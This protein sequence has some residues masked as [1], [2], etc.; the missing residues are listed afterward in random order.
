MSKIG[1]HNFFLKNKINIT[2]GYT[3]LNLG[4]CNEIRSLL[5]KDM[6]KIMEI[7]FNAGHSAELFLKNNPD[8]N[9]TSFDLGDHGYLLYGKEYID[10]MF[11]GRHTLIIGDSR[12]S[13]PKFIR[14]YPGVK[15]DLLFIDGGHEYEIAKAD[16]NNCKELAHKD[17]L[18]II[19][20]W[21]YDGLLEEIKYKECTPEI[22]SMIYN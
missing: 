22:Q 15:F 17:S 8:L 10:K 19:F 11:P 9:L 20:D 5:N 1:L 18:F 6:N 4:Q 16:L 7:G 13:I 21:S 3:Q 2:E 12:L 14:D